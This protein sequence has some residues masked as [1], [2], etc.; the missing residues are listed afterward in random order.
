M[1]AFI[2]NHAHIDAIVNFACRHSRYSTSLGHGL[3]Q[4]T[5]PQALGKLLIAENIRSVD[6][7]YRE[8]NLAAPYNW[9]PRCGDNTTPVA[10]LKL[11]SCL[12][13]QS[14]E[15]PDYFQTPACRALLALR[16]IG[17]KALPGYD[18]ADWEYPDHDLRPAACGTMRLVEDD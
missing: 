9:Q 12:E 8:R 1:S 6:Y 16:G 17:I 5:D 18:A 3:P 15:S 10:Y 4:T 7:R 11:L 2:V 14:C 13:Y